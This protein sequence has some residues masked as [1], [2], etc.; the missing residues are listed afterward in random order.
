M[1]NLKCLIDPFEYRR[2]CSTDHVVI[3]FLM[4]NL[5]ED[6]VSR[7]LR[8]NLAAAYGITLR[9]NQPSIDTATITGPDL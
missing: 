8:R 4:V 3:Y 6:L 2:V 1:L 5:S 7:I 9:Q